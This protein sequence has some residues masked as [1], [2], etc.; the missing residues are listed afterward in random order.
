MFSVHIRFAELED[1]PALMDIYNDYVICSSA[2]F[3]ITPKSIEERTAWFHAHPRESRW[4]I[5]TAL[6]SS[7]AAAGFTSSNPLRPK[8][9]YGTS[10][11]T[12]IYVARDKRHLGIGRRLYA[13]LFEELQ[14]EDI[15][16]AYACIALPNPASISL[17]E[18]FGFTPVGVFHEAGRKLGRYISIQWM[19]KILN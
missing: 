1:V 4:K 2:T 10:V 14:K 7:G 3:D 18:S 6:D 8:E 11:E 13:R 12:T 17:H 5:L 9:A 15:H 16:R 19:E